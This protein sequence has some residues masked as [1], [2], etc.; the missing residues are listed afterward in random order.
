MKKKLNVVV[1]LSITFLTTILSLFPQI[2]TYAAGYSFEYVGRFATLEVPATGTYTIEVWGGCGG[3]DSCKGGKGSYRKG[4]FTLTEGTILQIC[5]GKGDH[6]GGS[7]DNGSAGY[8]APAP[9]MCE[10]GGGGGPGGV[11]YSGY[12]GGASYVVTGSSKYLWDYSS[13]TNQI[14]L[15]AGGGGGGTQQRTGGNADASNAGGYEFGKGQSRGP[16]P[17]FDG[18]GGGAGYYGG[19][20]APDNGAT[21]G[22]TSWFNSSRGTLKASSNGTWAAS[23]KVIISLPGYDVKFRPN[24]P[25]VTSNAVQGTMQ[26]QFFASSV[27]GKL[28]KNTYTLTGYKWKHWTTNSDG[29]GTQYTDE[30][31][32][33]DIAPANSSIDLYAKWEPITYKVRYLS[34]NDENKTKMHP[35]TC[36]YDRSYTPITA[37]E[38]GFK[39][40][41]YYIK[42]WMHRPSR[43]QFYCGDRDW[44]IGTGGVIGQFKNLTNVADDVVDMHAIWEPIKYTIRIHENYPNGVTGTITDNYIDYVVQYDKDF[45]LP[46]SPWTHSSGIMLGYDFNKTVKVNPSMKCKSTAKNLTTVRDA[47]IDIY[48][49]WDLPPQ[50]TCPKEL[51]L[52]KNK[53][54]V[55]G[56]DI[57]NGTITRSDLEAWLLA[58]GEASDF[59]YTYRHAVGAKIPIGTAEG[60][61]YKISAI[62]P[63]D[64]IEDS[65]GTAASTYYVTY[66]VTDDAGQSA[67][68]TMTLYIGN[69]NV[70]ILIH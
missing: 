5:A 58:L 11:G 64:M 27:S 43:Q 62:E 22:G 28:R 13:N 10:I 35:E 29:S 9:G 68:A 17:G 26:D 2:P 7:C 60:Y 18:G 8:A 67:T 24:K 70:D 54:T 1:S 23:G 20:S 12:G 41:G 3:E 61:T 66:E 65:K 45:M 33:V 30:Q 40:I 57:S 42:Y 63:V 39:K 53:V 15:V 32:V 56:L 37:D 14:L 38:S 25:A 46:D 31:T 34:N 52:D 51:H 69:V 49:V 50:V 19:F 48:C 47:I 21:T 59:E 36:V 55:S 4:E 16:G 44:P 6:G